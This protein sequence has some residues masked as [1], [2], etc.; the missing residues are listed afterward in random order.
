MSRL[1][2]ISL[3]LVLVWLGALTLRLAFTARLG[4]DDIEHLH[5]AWLM[6]QGQQ[7]FID[8]F[9][10]QSPLLW[11][12]LLPLVSLAEGD[13]AIAVFLGRSLMALA[14]AA[15]VVAIWLLAREALR[16]KSMA[17]A[18][19]LLLG[20]SPAVLYNLLVIRPDMRIQP[21]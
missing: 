21:T 19:L 2:R 15:S 9:Q 16:R 8:F 17:P 6:L 7:P 14:L 13:L 20:A 18:A 11:W 12:L 1:Q 3:V 4:H 10:K 5:T